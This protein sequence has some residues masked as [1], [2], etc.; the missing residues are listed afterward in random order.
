MECYLHIGT[1][2]TG[3]TV[4]QN[5]LYSNEK[6]LNQNGIYL[7]KNIGKTNNRLLPEYFSS[8]LDGWA[9]RK[10]I[11][12]LKEKKIFFNGFLSKFENEIN[13]ASNKY[14]KIIISSEL[15]HLRNNQNEIEQL[16]SFLDKNFKSIKIICYF[17]NQYDA[18]LSAYSTQLK[19][20]V[21]KDILDIL[22]N[23]NE[24][25]HRYNYLNLADKWANIFKNKN[26]YFKVYDKNLFLSNDIRL[27]FLN[28]VEPNFDIQK[29]DFSISNDNESL[30]YLEMIAYLNINK[31]IPYFKKKNSGI[32][33]KNKRFKRMIKDSQ[34]FKFGKLDLNLRDEIEAKFSFSNENFF[35]KYF[36]SHNLFINKNDK[37]L[38]QEHLSIKEVEKIIEFLIDTFVPKQKKQ[39]LVSP[40]SYSKNIF[41]HLLFKLGFKY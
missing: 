9:K 22:K 5:W 23:I 41:R 20:G 2:K 21:K 11:A 16:H 18:I 26:C 24:E 12:N 35:K 7:P 37:P 13:K 3:T 32:N 30:K 39:N 14:H 36:N 15:F 31:K 34:L 33:F 17:R 10:K 19:N 4:L 6:V 25:S 29:L 8:R 28:L 27:D 1:A 38:N 40:D